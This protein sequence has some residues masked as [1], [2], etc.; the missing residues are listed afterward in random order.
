MSLALP[1]LGSVLEAS[2]ALGRASLRDREIGASSTGDKLAGSSNHQISQQ[3]GPGG[4][5]HNKGL[6]QPGLLEANRNGVL[7]LD[8]LGAD[9]DV[10]HAYPVHHHHAH[11]ERSRGASDASS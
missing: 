10:E 5:S 4:Y 7:C 1:V 8:L 9:C 11:E 3:D 2:K 6:L